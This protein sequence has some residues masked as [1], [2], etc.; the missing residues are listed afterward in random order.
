MKL[1]KELKKSSLKKTISLTVEKAITQYNSNFAS[2]KDLSKNGK[3]DYIFGLI[4]KTNIRNA[5]KI[6][7]LIRKYST[8]LLKNINFECNR[9]KKS[10]CYFKPIELMIKEIS[11]Y[12]EDW[13]Y[14]KEKYSDLNG[15]VDNYSEKYFNKIEIEKHF[16]I[17][18]TFNKFNFLRKK[19]RLILGYSKRLNILDKDGKIVCYYFDIKKNRCKIQ[20]SRKKETTKRF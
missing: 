16:G 7:V 8:L 18:L 10:C 9:C 20:S 1:P 15:F 6:Y 13:D 11:I 4:E 17:S 3:A 19:A 12:K 5:R 14:L 2:F